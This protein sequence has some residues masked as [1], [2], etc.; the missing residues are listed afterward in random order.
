MLVLVV[1]FQLS[2]STLSTRFPLTFCC[3]PSLPTDFCYHP[4]LPPALWAS[5]GHG[6]DP[7]YPLPCGPAV[8]MGLRCF[9]ELSDQFVQTFRLFV[10]ILSLIV[11]PFFWTWSVIFQQHNYP[12]MC[13]EHSFPMDV[14]STHQID[15][16]CQCQVHDYFPGFLFSS[17]CSF[18]FM[19]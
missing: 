4:N 13:S 15:G 11:S 6:A 18:F 16:H 7:I 8:G 12:R 19:L 3:H 17:F 2:C 9:K 10:F 5:C 1:G 14:S